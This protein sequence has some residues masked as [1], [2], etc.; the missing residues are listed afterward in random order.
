MAHGG[1]RAGYHLWHERQVHRGDG[2]EFEGLERRRIDVLDGPEQFARQVIERFRNPFLRHKLFDIAINQAAKRDIR[3]A[4]TYRE[5]Q[6]K[7]GHVP[8]L[9]DEALKARET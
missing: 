1:G 4:P 3:L 5:Y 6:A 7:F 9:L 2:E 8:P